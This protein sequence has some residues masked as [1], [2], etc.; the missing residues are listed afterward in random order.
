LYLARLRHELDRTQR[1]L[2]LRERQRA[3]LRNELWQVRRDFRQLDSRMAWINQQRR[4]NVAARLYRQQQL[5]AA[6][7]AYDRDWRRAGIPPQQPQADSARQADIARLRQ[8]QQNL[9]APLSGRDNRIAASNRQLEN[10]LP[11]STSIAQLTPRLDLAD[12]DDDGVADA[13]DLCPDTATTQGAAGCSIDQPVAME[14]V[15]FRYDSYELT[16]DSRQ[17]LGHVAGILKQHPD[18]KLEVAG[19]TDAQG[20][21]AYNVWLSQMRAE[22]VRDYLLDEGVASDNLLAKGYGGEQPIADNDTLEGLR[23]NRRVELHLLL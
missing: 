16:D 3:R 4:Q 22:T 19:H 1:T 14:G 21:P 2:W 20:N 6:A 15:N 13:R 5:A 11:P 10:R 7:S 18:L 12:R 17:V 8:E 9:R 23:S